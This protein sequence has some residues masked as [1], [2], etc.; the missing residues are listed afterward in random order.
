MEIL[1]DMHLTPEEEDCKD[2]QN[3]SVEHINEVTGHPGN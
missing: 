1:E 3:L 2:T